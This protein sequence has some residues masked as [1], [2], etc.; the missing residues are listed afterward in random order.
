[1]QSAVENSVLPDTCIIL[2]APAHTSDG[3]GGWSD[4]RGTVSA[5][6]ACRL[7]FLTGREVDTAGAIQP[8]TRWLLN[9]P[10]GTVVASNYR[11]VIGGTNYDAVADPNTGASW[12]T[13]V[14]VLVEKAK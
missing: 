3:Q 7:D 8:Y 14:Q 5:S 6:C 9:L 11:F 2:G 10:Y 13:C 1:M 4:A 12:A